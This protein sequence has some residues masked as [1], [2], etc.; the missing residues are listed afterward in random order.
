MAYLVFSSLL[1]YVCVLCVCG[2]GMFFVVGGVLVCLYVLGCICVCMCREYICVFVY[3]VC[4]C[5]WFVWYV[6][7]MCGRCMMCM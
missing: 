6:Y 1:V 2:G 4:V 3:C 5:I 7:M